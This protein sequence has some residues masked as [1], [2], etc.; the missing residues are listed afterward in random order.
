MKTKEDNLYKQMA[1]CIKHKSYSIVY[2]PIF[3]WSYIFFNMYIFIYLIIIINIIY[4]IILY[5]PY[6]YIYDSEL[7]DQTW[8][9]L[10]KNL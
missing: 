2:F 6:I 9:L 10:A 1:Q 4:N 8:P 5:M 7:M 3:C